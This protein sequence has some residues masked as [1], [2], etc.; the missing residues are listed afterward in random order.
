M[1]KSDRGHL[2]TNQRMW[3]K[4]L[5]LMTT[6]MTMIS[7]NLATRAPRNRKMGVVAR[8]RVVAIARKKAV[9][10]TAKIRAVS[11]T[12]PVAVAKA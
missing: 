9:V 10:V 8:I 1:P 2:P 5:E 11:P 3:G 12:N 7:R 6:T 4:R